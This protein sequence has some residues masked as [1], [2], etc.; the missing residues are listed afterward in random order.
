MIEYY[1]RDGRPLDQRSAWELMEDIEYKRVASTDVGPYWV[2]TVWL[3]LDHRWIGE[4]PPVIFETMVFAISQREDGTGCGEFDTVRYC[5]EAEALAGHE[6]MVT[7]VRA[8]TQE[9]FD[10][11]EQPGLSALPADGPADEGPGSTDPGGH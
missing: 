7:L 9:E 2:S 11:R 1:G 3:G 10:G 4:G 6:E 5:T 8:T